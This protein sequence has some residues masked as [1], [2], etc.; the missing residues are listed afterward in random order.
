MWEELEHII[1]ASIEKNGD[2][3][4]T[5]SHFLNIIRHANRNREKEDFID[6]IGECGSIW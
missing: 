2:K 4:L 5:L 6:R 3:P 1:E